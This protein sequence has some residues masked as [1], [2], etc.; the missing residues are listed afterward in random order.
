MQ[1]GKLSSPFQST[2]SIL[3]K[4]SQLTY[5]TS[6]RSRIMNQFVVWSGDDVD[7][8][9]ADRQGDGGVIIPQTITMGT[10][11]RRAVEPLVL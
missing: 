7:L 8:G 5:W 1:T 2:I 10:I 3:E 9:A 4:Q 11:T 6:A